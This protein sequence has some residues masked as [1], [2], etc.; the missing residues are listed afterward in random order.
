LLS[1]VLLGMIYDNLIITIGK[2]IAEC[3]LL[4]RLNQL[5]FCFHNLLVPLLVITA[6]NIAADLGITWATSPIVSYISWAIA[7]LL[8]ISGLATFLRSPDLIATDFAGTLRYKPQQSSIPLTTIL[9][10]VLVAITGGWIWYV[11]RWHWMFTGTTVM[12]AGN[13]LPKNIFGTLIGSAVDSMFIF[14]LLTTA[15]LLS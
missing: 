1:V 9:T 10:A 3:S 8:M 6:I 5:R 14:S 13:A 12:L 4:K 2:L 7:L 15:L 11:T